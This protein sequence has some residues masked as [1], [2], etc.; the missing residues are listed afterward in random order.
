MV[1]EKSQCYYALLLALITLLPVTAL[2]RT[3]RV[4]F[5][6]GTQDMPSEA[7]LLFGNEVVTVD[8]PTRFL[9]PEIDI[10]N[11][12]SMAYVL[13][14]PPKPE[15]KISPSAPVIRFPE[16]STRS[17][18]LFIPDPKNSVFPARV[19]VI[20]AS[21]NEFPE[22]HTVIFNLSKTDIA[23]K[24]GDEK[25]SVKAG[26][27]IVLKPPRSDAGGYPVHIVCRSDPQADWATL[28]S[29]TWRHHPKVRQIMFI[30]PYKDRKNPRIWT[31]IDRPQVR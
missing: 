19:M 20:D 25:V 7:T 4:M 2:S 3:T 16:E 21:P 18:L 10:P 14:E 8:L 11:S 15:E 28:C 26:Q 23:G 22:G 31:I 30:A 13:K 24:F 9:S 6:G 1:D 27:R 5:L 17:L 29:S 12:P